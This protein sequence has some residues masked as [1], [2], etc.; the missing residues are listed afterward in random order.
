M[1]A[2][3]GKSLGTDGPVGQFKITEVRQDGRVTIVASGELDAFTL[4]QLQRA[5]T[6]AFAYRPRLVSRVVSS[7]RILV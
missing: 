2:E 3:N 5:L 6:E 7:L 1:S 4:P